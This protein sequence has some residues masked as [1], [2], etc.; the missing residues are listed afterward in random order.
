MPA[1]TPT[2][3]MDQ[4]FSSFAAAS[5]GRAAQILELEPGELTPEEL[6]CL[7]I[8]HSFEQISAATYVGFPL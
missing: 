5:E 3:T 8:H 2:F 4:L 7:M 1:E 6:C